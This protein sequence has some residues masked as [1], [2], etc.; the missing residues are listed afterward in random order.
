MNKIKIKSFIIVIMLISMI[1][2]NIPMITA[3]SDASNPKLQETLAVTLVIDNSGSMKKTDPEHLRQTAANIFIDLLSPEDYLSVITFNTKQKVTI[4]M[5]QIKNSS[6]KAGF[7]SILSKSIDESGDTD[8]LGALNEAGRQ[9]DSMKKGNVRKVILFLTD[10]EPDPDGS[11]VINPDYMNSLW[12]SVSDLALKKYT[13]Y[14]VGFSEGVNPDVLKRISSDTQGSLKITNDA[15]KI[16]LSFFDILGKL[17]NR[18]EFINETIDLSGNKNLKFYLDEYTSQ[19]TMVFTNPDG[20]PFDVKLTVPD[21]K[22]PG[23][24]AVINKYDKYIVVTINQQDKKLTRNWNVNLS[25]SGSITVFG[26]KDLIIKPWLIAPEA[27]SLHPLNEP[28]DISVNITGEIKEGLSAEAV[29]T[30][31]GA[32][33]K[34]PVKLT[35]EDRVFTGT[36]KKTDKPGEYN[37][38]IKLMINGQVI[39]ENNAS[40]TVRELPS[41]YT[42]FVIRDSK[43]K[44]GDSLIVTSSLNL[45]GG[46]LINGEGIKID[47]YNLL[48]NYKNSGFVS[49]PLLDNGSAKNEDVKENDGIWSNRVLFDKADSGDSAI[50]VNGTYNGEKFLLEKPLGSFSVYAPGKIVIKPLNINLYTSLNRRLKITFEIENTSNLSENLIISIDKSIGSLSEN[51]IKIGPHKKVKAYVY[52]NLNKNL[53]QKTYNLTVKI[54]GE[55]GKTKIE[56]SKFSIKFQVLSKIGYLLKYIKEKMIPVACFL[57]VFTGLFLIV[58][59][60][61]LFLYRILVYKKTIIRGGVTFFKESDSCFKEI[62]KFDFNKLGKG[63][64]IISFDKNNKN[65]DFRIFDSEFN[66]DIE[67]S[68]ITKRSKWKFVDGYNALFHKNNASGI[69]LRTTEPGIFTYSEKIFTNRKIYNNDVF[70]TG[71]YV[72]QYVVSRKEKSID[73]EKGKN[74]LERES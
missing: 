65:A 2:S 62:N 12:K 5:Q 31:D 54:N 22:D 64:V 34:T 3:A 53:K 24:A 10:G 51:S 48:L 40:F 32:V 26:N 15:G 52:V 20:K 67:F 39:T 69:F 56:P 71:G 1:F 27:N 70:I 11:S 61:G 58:V 50:I 47:N 46:K 7:K 74:I 13:V 44:L 68:A 37:I 49:I 21:G 9:L 59:L 16:A 18:N 29:I 19:A 43:I 66:Y 30:K 28:L 14:S 57:G 72:F 38:D 63:K 25:G 33:D 60:L 4:P 36:Y 45:K 73:N 35:L 17:K 55:D 41:I 6:N 23:S 8:Y 42:D